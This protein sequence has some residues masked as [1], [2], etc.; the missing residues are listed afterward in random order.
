MKVAETLAEQSNLKTAAAISP[1]KDSEKIFLEGPRSRLKELVFAIKVLIEFISGFR[2]LH[3]LGPCVAVFGS[4]RIKE[5]SPYYESAREIGSGL[6]ALGF[7]TITGGGPGI[8][9]AAN[10]GA[11]ENAGASVGCNIR[12]PKEQQP[13]P[14]LD[15]WFICKYFFVRKVLMFKYSDAFIIMPGGIGTL[16]EFFEALTLVQTKKILDFP[17]IL[18]GTKFWEPLQPLFSSMLKDKMISEE[19]IDLLLFTDSV[20]DA[21]QHIKAIALAKHAEKR[22]QSF[23]RLRILG[24]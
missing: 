21:L 7:T 13:N 11:R 15:K 10:R 6:A 16:D 20:E 14:Y 22:R 12:L 24:E 8:M 17:I 9:E 3:F 4:A 1:L 18:F 2:M 5:D 19:D 23:R